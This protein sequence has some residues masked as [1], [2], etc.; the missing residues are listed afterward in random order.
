MSYKT[1]APDRY[2]LLKEFARK[3][4]K[5]ATLAETILWEYLRKGVA[6]EKFLRQ[7][8]IGDYIADFVSRHGG[9]IVEVDGGY[10]SEPRQTENDAIR[11]DYLESIGYHVMRFTNEEVLNDPDSVLTQIEHYFNID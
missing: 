9:L 3:N 5:E 7:H 8:V 11:E 1:A 10:H 6:G 2:G 4:R